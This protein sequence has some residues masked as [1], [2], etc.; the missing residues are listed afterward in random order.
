MTDL[1]LCLKVNGTWKIVQKVMTTENALITSLRSALRTL[2]AHL[3]YP[4]PPF[5]SLAVTQH[6]MACFVA[7][8]NARKGLKEFPEIL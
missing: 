3:A 6:W 5:E 7:W 4:R 2:K 8:C 1:L